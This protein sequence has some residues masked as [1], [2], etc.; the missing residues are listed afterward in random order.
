M[1]YTVLY[2]ATLILIIGCT[3]S[4]QFCECRAPF[5]KSLQLPNSDVISDEILTMALK[6]LSLL[7]DLGISIPYGR[8]YSIE[9]VYEACPSLEKLRVTL[10]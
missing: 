2:A 7:E 10:L 8:G 6:R 4:I 1:I 9:S 3:D 5:L